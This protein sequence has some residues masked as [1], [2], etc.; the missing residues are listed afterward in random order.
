MTKRSEITDSMNNSSAASTSINETGISNAFTGN[1]YTDLAVYGITLHG[2]TIRYLHSPNLT[3]NTITGR[4]NL[5]GREETAGA[6]SYESLIRFVVGKYMEHRAYT[7]EC[8]RR[9]RMS[10]IT[11]S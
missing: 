10:F 3:G 1:P 9:K 11:A 2:C 5:S 7:A 4:F 6:T 8:R